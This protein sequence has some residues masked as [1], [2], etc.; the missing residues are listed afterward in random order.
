[1]RLLEYDGI[2]H[3]SSASMWKL[4]NSEKIISYITPFP[5]QADADIILALNFSAALHITQTATRFVITIKIQI[6][7][8]AACPK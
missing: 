1:M 5:L 6:L 2:W 3:L 7:L 8:T 4:L